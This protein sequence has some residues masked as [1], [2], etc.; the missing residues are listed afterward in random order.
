M[1]EGREERRG[2]LGTLETFLRSKGRGNVNDGMV[3]LS[4]LH[5][6]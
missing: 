5:P 3:I 4:L 2:Y 6:L 1:I